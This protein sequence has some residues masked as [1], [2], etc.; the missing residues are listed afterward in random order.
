MRTLSSTILIAALLAPA[1]VLANAF[2]VPLSGPHPTELLV[3]RTIHVVDFHADGIDYYLSARIVG[4]GRGSSDGAMR[5]GMVVALPDVPASAE[6]I[7]SGLFVGLDGAT[8][9]EELPCE[10]SSGGCSGGGGFASGSGQASILGGNVPLRA[11]RI[12]TNAAEALDFLKAH[13]IE[14]DGFVRDAV[15]A[16]FARELVV[17][18]GYLAADGS[19]APVNFGNVSRAVSLRFSYPGAGAP[20]RIPLDVHPP[21]AEEAIGEVSTNLVVVG[22]ARGAIEGAQMLAVDRGTVD[23]SSASGAI[24]GPAAPVSDPAFTPRSFDRVVQAT[25]HRRGGSAWVRETAQFLNASR[26]SAAMPACAIG[27]D[28]PECF[29]R[30]LCGGS[31]ACF[32]LPPSRPGPPPLD[33]GFEGDGGL[34][35]GA[36]ADGG[37]DAGDGGDT[38]LHDGGLDAGSSGDAGSLDAGAGPT[39]TLHVALT[40][41]LPRDRFVTRLTTLS[42]T[43]DLRAVT[44]TLEESSEGIGPGYR[45][46]PESEDRGCSTAPGPSSFALLGLTL[47]LITRARFA[48]R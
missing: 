22:R 41:L 42:R 39:P 3:G 44:V 45:N 20:F 25:L 17:W 47:A 16:I 4:S 38:D 12:A 6:P 36:G 32:G 9:G 40:R 10:S 28:P 21:A 27:E 31:D 33:A 24:A 34:D 13:G 18:V 48:R 5:F 14:S 29:E 43:T 19:E 26:V 37:S 11:A 46:C 15:E 7:P 1:A 23:S 35:E 8:S 2:P 30:A